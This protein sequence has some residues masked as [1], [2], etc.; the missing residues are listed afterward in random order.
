MAEPFVLTESIL[1]GIKKLLGMEEDYVAFDTDII[2]L[3][4]DALSSANQQ[5][6][7]PTDLK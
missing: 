4:N 5:D 1:T 3:I 7:C 6:L 2:F